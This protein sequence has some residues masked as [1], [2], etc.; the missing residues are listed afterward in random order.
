MQNETEFYSTLIKEVRAA[1]YDNIEC[2]DEEIRWAFSK[3]QLR[4]RDILVAY[5]DQKISLS[6]ISR[7]QGVTRQ[8]IHDYKR[9]AL[10]LMGKWVR[11]ERNANR[12]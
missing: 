4:K 2:T 5:F 10:E 12:Q 9:I 7:E 3:L 11:R 6:E 1:T 8:A